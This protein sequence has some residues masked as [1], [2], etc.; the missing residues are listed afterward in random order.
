MEDFFIETRRM[1]IEAM[2]KTPDSPPSASEAEKLSQYYDEIIG[3][4]STAAPKEIEAYL[5][6]R[7]CRSYDQL[8]RL[9][10]KRESRNLAG[11]EYE[12]FLGRLRT[13]AHRGRQKVLKR[14]RQVYKTEEYSAEQLPSRST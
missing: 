11:E 3:D 4:I 13:R 9:I 2:G 14:L 12:R 6:L 5:S 7:N 8:A 10:Q 1:M